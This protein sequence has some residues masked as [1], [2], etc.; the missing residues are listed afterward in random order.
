MTAND[1]RG[2]MAKSNEYKDKTIAEIE[3]TI[4]DQARQGLDWAQFHFKVGEAEEFIQR[5]TDGLVLA[6]FTVQRSASSIVI[7]W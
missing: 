5:V 2:I 1:A 3:T 6:D 4:R 7:K